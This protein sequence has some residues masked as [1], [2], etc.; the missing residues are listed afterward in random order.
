MNY[1]IKKAVIPVAGLGTR[2]LPFTKSAPKE[3]LPILNRPTIDY[4]VE[5]AI[6]SGIEIIIFITSST[7]TPIIDY[8]DRNLDLER[9]LRKKGKDSQAEDLKNLSEKAKFISVRQHDAKGLG[10]AVLQ[11]KEIIGD[12]PFALMLGD[13]V[14]YNPEEPALKQLIKLAEKEKSSVLGVGEVP[15]EVVS[16][17]G[18]VDPKETIDEKTILLKGVVEKPA[19][20]V[21]PSNLSIMGRYILSPKIFEFLEE[22]NIDPAT[23]EI[24]ITDSILKLMNYEK[25]YAY[26]FD[27][28]RYDMGSKQGYIKAN[29]EYALRDSELKSTVLETIKLEK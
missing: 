7:K 27:G 13:D 29:I 4:I 11:A 3:M 5:E 26:K 10:H 15:I 12:E 16:N 21:A 24:Q 23:N 8:F 20:E 25:I 14:I 22:N 6:N 17:Y 2:F 9:Q 1:K 19:K 28:I 18:V